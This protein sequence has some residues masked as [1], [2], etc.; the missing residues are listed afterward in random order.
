[1]LPKILI[2]LSILALCFTAIPA[3]AE[4][5]QEQ[6]IVPNLKNW[7]FTLIKENWFELIVAIVVFIF[8]TKIYFTSQNK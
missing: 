3:S 7:L 6:N 4:W 8:G 1:M 2:R 5:F